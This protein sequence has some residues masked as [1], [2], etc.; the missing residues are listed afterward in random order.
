M[1]P[2]C[3]CPKRHRRAMPKILYVCTSNTCRSPAAATIARAHLE[4]IGRTDVEIASRGLTDRYSA[5]GSPPDPRAE[6]ALRGATGLSSQGHASSKLTAKE[7]DECDALFYFMRE[8]VDWIA[9][10]V[11]KA[12]VKR[13]LESGRLRIVRPPDG[14][15]D[16]FFAD[17][18]FYGEVMGM[19]QTHVARSLDEVLASI[20]AFEVY[21][22]AQEDRAR[23]TTR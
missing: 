6:K 17:D 22:K 9:G 14:I 15:P 18:A 19:L 13:A 2:L 4:K 1:L 3:C 23:L 7:V 16:P 20:H 12:P 21:R 11:G 8:H 10:C 5:W